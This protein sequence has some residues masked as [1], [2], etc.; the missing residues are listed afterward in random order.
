MQKGENFPDKSVV[1]LRTK[2]NSSRSCSGV[3][4]M[5]TKAIWDQPKWRLKLSKSCH[6]DRRGNP[7]LVHLKVEVIQD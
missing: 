2:L 3:A 7:G 6:S 5:E 4:E 1:L